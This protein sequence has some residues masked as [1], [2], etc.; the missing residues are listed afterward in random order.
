MSKHRVL[1]AMDRRRGGYGP[2][3]LDALGHAAD[4]AGVAVNID[5]V[6]TAKLRAYECD[7]DGILVGPGSPY[8][9]MEAVLGLIRRA[10]TEGLPLLG[11]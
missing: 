5:W 9:D 7:A 2:Q 3:T 6:E 10:R 1:L 11:T 8:D 4:A